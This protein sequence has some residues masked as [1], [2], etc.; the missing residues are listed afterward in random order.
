MFANFPSAAFGTEV[1]FSI[2]FS[3]LTQQQKSKTKQAEQ[4]QPTKA[5]QTPVEVHFCTAWRG[6]R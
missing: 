2:A 5:H 4:T 1:P 3:A 6:G